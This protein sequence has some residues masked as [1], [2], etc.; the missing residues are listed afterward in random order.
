[1]FLLIFFKTFKNE[2]IRKLDEQIAEKERILNASTTKIAKVDE[3]MLEIQAQLERLRLER[4]ESEAESQA[5]R[6]RKQNMKLQL[7]NKSM[8]TSTST[9]E[10]DDVSKSDT[11]E[12]C[13]TFHTALP[14]PRKTC[15][16]A[17]YTRMRMAHR[18]INGQSGSIILSDLCRETIPKCKTKIERF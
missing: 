14:P 15:S 12:T 1:M 2:E 6:T 13:D 16:P 18:L 17:A 8:S 3:T 5:M 11:Y 9:N 4:A 7:A 10:A